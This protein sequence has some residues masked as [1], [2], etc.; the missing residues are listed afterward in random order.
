MVELMIV[1]LMLGIVAAT[2]LPEMTHSLAYNRMTAG[3]CELVTALR[4]AQR[5]A[6]GSSVNVRVRI[7]T[8]SDTFVVE[9]FMPGQDLSTDLGNEVSET[10]VES[11]TFVGMDHPLIAGEQ[12]YVNLAEQTWFGGVDITDVDFSG[13]NR[14]VF[15]TL[16][17]PSTGGTI[18]LVYGSYEAKITV[19][20]LSG[21]VDV[22][23]TAPGRGPMQGDGE[24]IPAE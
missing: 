22:E 24:A 2:A 17:F 18:T 15:C 1:L 3:A 23:F 13:D 21:D 19:D 6:L 20:A 10:D 8:A 11:G 7:E 16:G 5:T 14:V 9:K 4:Y 12:Y